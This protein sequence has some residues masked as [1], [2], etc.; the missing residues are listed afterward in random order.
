MAKQMFC[1]LHGVRSEGH[2]NRSRKRAAEQ[3]AKSGK[4]L[5]KLFRTRNIDDQAQVPAGVAI[6]RKLRSASL[7]FK[8]E[9]SD[10]VAPSA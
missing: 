10:R 5:V 9:I 3:I 7:R 1:V 2:Q 4:S 8:V 6:R